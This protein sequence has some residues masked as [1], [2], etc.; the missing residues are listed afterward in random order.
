MKSLLRNI[1]I[2]S[3]MIAGS[4]MADTT[5][6]T[7]AAFDRLQHD[8]KPILVAVHADWCPVCRAQAPVIES[9]LRQK[10][11]QGIASLRVDFDN[12]KEIVQAFRVSRQSTLIVFTGG[13]EV[14]R[15]LG[16][17]TPGGIESLLR[18]A[19]KE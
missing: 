19:L 2:L 1:L 16:D 5:P 7:Q 18:K 4:A 12:Q 10:K 6:Y 14:G 17:T 15:S 13:K 3:F 9:L 11:F 8:G